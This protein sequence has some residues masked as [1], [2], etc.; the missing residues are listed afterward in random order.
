MDHPRYGFRYVDA[1]DL[2][3]SCKEFVGLAV[4]GSDGNKLG[5]VE[6]FV[7]DLAEGIPR[8][9]AVEAGW[10]IH[11]HF[12][13]PIGHVTLAADGQSL[14]AD[15]NAERVKRFPGFDKSEFDK[16]T[17]EDVARLDH[18]LAS[19]CEGVQLSADSDLGTHYKTPGWWRST[20]YQATGS[21]RR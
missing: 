14:V 10:F 21:N 4:N 12:L 15:I 20:T 8:H 9:V 18:V 1:K 2:D 16:L 3:D 6:G 11:K 7:I 17:R 5:N 19:A 13:L